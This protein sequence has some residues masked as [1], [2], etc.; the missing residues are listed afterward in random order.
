MLNLQ[1]GAAA[2]VLT[3]F[4][5]FVEYDDV[6]FHLL[7]VLGIILKAKKDVDEK[8]L[9]NLICLLEHVTMHDNSS[10]KEDSKQKL[11]CLSNIIPLI[12]T[13]TYLR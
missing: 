2:A 9:L 4:Q 6:L 11:F 10:E 3:R 12:Q 8:F 13:P 7:R 5:E 1:T